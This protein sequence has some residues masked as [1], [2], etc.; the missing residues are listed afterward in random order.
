[1]KRSEQPWRK[2][3]SR[4][5]LGFAPNLAIARSPQWDILRSILCLEV[6]DAAFREGTFQKLEGSWRGLRY[7][8]SPGETSAM[9]KIKVL[10]V[11]KKDLLRDLQRA[12]PFT[13]PNKTHWP[14]D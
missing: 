9:L 6:L 12:P 5:N 13:E 14:S 10:N 4:L 1:M 2:L 7:L 8:L 11:S 3:R